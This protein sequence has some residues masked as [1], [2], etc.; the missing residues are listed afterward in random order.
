[1]GDDDNSSTFSDERSDDDGFHSNSDGSSHNTGTNSDSNSGTSHS[2]SRTT[3]GGD[4]HMFNRDGGALSGA[5]CCFVLTLIVAAC[6]LATVVSLIST[7]N[8]SED[9][10]ASFDNTAIL[11]I[12]TSNNNV[13]R[14]FRSLEVLSLTATSFIKQDA[15]DDTNGNYPP[16]FI[17]LP[18]TEVHLGNARETA[19]AFTVGYTPIVKDAFE[20]NMW[21]EYSS[22]NIG[23]LDESRQIY[24]DDQQASSS[25]G[26]GFNNN[27]WYMQKYDEQGNLIVID[28]ET[29]LTC[30]NRESNTAAEGVVTAVANESPANGPFSPIWMKSPPPSLEEL[31]NV[32]FN[33]ERDPI[34][35]LAEQQMR[36]TKSSSFQDICQAAST[37]FNPEERDAEKELF[38]L[39]TTPAWDDHS[40]GASIVGSFFGIVPWE[41]YF[42]DVLDINNRDPIN[43][44]MRS[45]CGNKEF[46]YRI[47]GNNATLISSSNDVHETEQL[48]EAMAHSAPFAVYAADTVVVDTETGTGVGEEDVICTSTSFT[49]TVYPTSEYESNYK[50]DEPLFYTLV[51]LGIFI[52][53]ILA[54][55]FFDCMVQRRQTSIMTTALRQNALVSS[56]FPKNIQKQLMADLDVDPVKNKSGKAGLRSFLN[57]EAT[58]G[59]SDMEDGPASNGLNS[60]PIADLFPETTIMFADI[61]GFTAW[62][63]TRE[64]TAV[65]TLLEAIYAEFDS[66][67]K[68]RRVFKVEVVGDCYVAVA[69]LPDPRPDHA[70]VMAKFANDCLNKMFK[71]VRKLEVELGPDTAELGLRVGLHSGPVVAGV[72]RGDKS[73]FQ[74][75]GDTMNTASR[76]ESNGVQGRIQLSNDTAQLLI[77]AEKEHWL[78][79]REDKVAAKGKGELQ[80]FFLQIDGPRSKPG[81]SAGSVTSNSSGFSDD[82]LLMPDPTEVQ[83]RR[84]R[85]AEWTV[86]V[87]AQQ[88]KSIVAIRKYQHVKADPSSTLKKL[89]DESVSHTGSHVTVIDEVAE[90]IKLPSYTGA[91]KKDISKSDMDDSL[92]SEVMEELRSFVQTIASLYNENPFHS[93]DHANH[94]VM[95]VNK[96]LSRINAPDVDDLTA[97]QIHDHTYGITSDPIT[98]FGCIFSAL[99]HDVDHSGVPNAQLVKEKAPVASLYNGRSVAEQNSFDMAWDLLMEPTYGNL[100]KTIYVNA[101]EF[102]RFRQLVV[103]GVM[104]T[105]IVDKDMKT[106]RNNRWDAAFDE[107]KEESEARGRTLKATII[108]EHLIQASDVAHTM[109]HWHIYRRWNERFFN[110]CY[111]AYLDGRAE[112]N[113][114]DGWYK[115]EMGF[116]DF[117][118]IPLAKKLKECGVFGVSSDEYLSYANQN[119]KEWEERGEEMVKEM[120]SNARKKQLKSQRRDSAN[121]TPE[122]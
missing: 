101:S 103:N 116:F 42:T 5:R 2:G 118:I 4:H 84:N 49:M 86:E 37:W 87:M 30:P 107:S 81:S 20:Y 12:E 26:T 66:I 77:A 11:F 55:F 60:K 41:T 56:L 24:Y 111:Q 14:V 74:L 32:N 40:E 120:I 115:G 28:E 62:S 94:V 113:P 73:R 72:L 83:A 22:D 38:S 92:D 104:A 21:R 82:N 64:P 15:L 33:L 75:F 69:G 34:Y 80:T 35:K 78:K 105:D 48:Y 100:R 19:N 99:I 121:V 27:I 90:C 13:D 10:Q 36:L 3:Q 52:F 31:S 76:M 109:Q 59:G 114:A 67:A 51:V 46:T 45:D 50:T 85:V 119:R 97:Q 122:A 95:S 25:G 63:S 43:V 93:F 9:F 102:K 88:L 44:V 68:R 98:W 1:K 6:A 108:I 8:E 18:D 57:D 29:A 53:T 7:N 110:E 71:M 79:E 39:V 58:G 61:A 65:F 91:D 23:W 89:E 106:L 112:T 117:Y 16:G 54:F 17:T 47:L 70:V 96:L